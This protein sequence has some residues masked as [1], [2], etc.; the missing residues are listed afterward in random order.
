MKVLYLTNLPAPYRRQ[1]FNAL[2]KFCNLTVIYENG[3]S[4]SSR[5]KKWVDNTK[6]SYQEMALQNDFPKTHFESCNNLNEFLRGQYDYIVIGGYSSWTEIKAV[7]FLS[8]NKIPFIISSDGGFVK[9]DNKFKFLIKSKLMSSASY[10]MSSGK[11]T[12]KYLVHYG[13]KEKNI[14]QYHFTSLD[15]QDILPKEMNDTEKELLKK[16]LGVEE[17]T[18]AVFVGQFIPRKGVDILAS[19]GKGLSNV[20]FYLI[21]SDGFDKKYSNQCRKEFGNNFHE[22]PFLTKDELN[23]YYEAA[24]IFVLPTKEDIW[25]LVINEAMAK[26]LPIITTTRCLAGLELVDDSNGRLVSPNNIEEL[27]QALIDLSS[28]NLEKMSKSS[29]AKIK[30]YTFEQMARDYFDA[31]TK[32]NNYENSSN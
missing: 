11:E 6:Y 21:G 29:L 7:R 28:S 27:R 2:G 20:G 16:R 26:G 5:N 25:G 8:K 4:D 24:D 1:F 13:A 10:W 3:S 23:V 15:R 14:F 32:I 30:D 12:T 22:I 19:A 18:M 9:K 31:F 17:K